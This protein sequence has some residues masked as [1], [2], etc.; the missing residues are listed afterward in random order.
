[1]EV[2]RISSN[3]TSTATAHVLSWGPWKTTSKGSFVGYAKSFCHCNFKSYYFTL[4][5][6]ILPTAGL[7]YDIFSY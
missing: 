7:R 3:L 5:A 4:R 1:M 2:H 6:T